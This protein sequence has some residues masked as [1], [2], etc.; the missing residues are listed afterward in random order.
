MTWL[1]QA[2]TGEEA[3]DI[4]DKVDILRLAAS[5]YM[6]VTSLYVHSISIAASQVKGR[7]RAEPKQKRRKTFQWDAARF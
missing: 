1:R 2:W 7:E 6:E 5:G 4:T 3:S